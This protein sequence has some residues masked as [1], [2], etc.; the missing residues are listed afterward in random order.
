MDIEKNDYLL[1]INMNHSI[2]EIRKLQAKK[3]TLIQEYRSVSI[4]EKK[5]TIMI[6][7]DEIDKKLEKLLSEEIESEEK[8]P[9][10]VCSLIDAIIDCCEGE[11]TESIRTYCEERRYPLW[12]EMSWGKH[13]HKIGSVLSLMGKCLIVVGTNGIVVDV[14][15]KI[16]LSPCRIG[17]IYIGESGPKIEFTKTERFIVHVDVKKVEDYRLG[18]F[19]WIKKKVPEIE[20]WDDGVWK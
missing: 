13:K 1:S 14:V 9:G 5:Q 18:N 17:Q 4:P 7:L 8:V 12:Y 6:L 10:E 19:V 3:K 15:G 2:D 20:N 11:T 16:T